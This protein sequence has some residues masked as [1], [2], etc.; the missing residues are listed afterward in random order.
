MVSV[1]QN[2]EGPLVAG[3]KQKSVES[4]CYDMDDLKAISGRVKKQ[5]H[6]SSLFQAIDANLDPEVVIMINLLFRKI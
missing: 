2:Y 6:I 4:L 3:L 5:D 1:E